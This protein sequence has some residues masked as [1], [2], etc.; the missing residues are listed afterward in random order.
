MLFSFSYNGQS[1]S[2]NEN[3]KIYEKQMQTNRL[4]VQDNRIRF[5]SLTLIQTSFCFLYSC[6]FLVHCIHYVFMGQ[7]PLYMKLWVL[8]NNQIK[9]MDA[10]LVD[11]IW[12]WFHAHK[13]H[14]RVT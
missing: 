7:L 4:I 9:Q 11:Q 14:T 1:I 6:A 3:P 10:I 13:A 8:S 2:Q 5:I 12:D